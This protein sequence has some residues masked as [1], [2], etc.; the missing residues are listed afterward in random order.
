MNDQPS[1]QEMEEVRRDRL[2]QLSEASLRINESLDLDTVLQEV[3]DTARSLTEARYSLITNLDESGQVED[4][5]A[6]GLSPEES[7]SLMEMLEES[8]YLECIEG[9]AGPFRTG[10]L[11][12]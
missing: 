8:G 6:S 10:D 7:Q 11:A 3:L 4:F 9:T 2:S 5:L 1:Q 12:G